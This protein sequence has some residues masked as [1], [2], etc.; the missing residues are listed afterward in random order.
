MSPSC[1]TVRLDH[2]CS[3]SHTH[4]RS[5]PPGWH[6][7][8]LCF[9]GPAVFSL[10]Y[11]HSE[12]FFFSLSQWAL[13]KYLN[14]SGWHPLSVPKNA[15]CLGLI[16]KGCVHI[17]L[18]FSKCLSQ[19]PLYEKLPKPVQSAEAFTTRSHQNA[20]APSCAR[21]GSTADLVALPLVEL[22][23][24]GLGGGFGL[25]RLH[26]QMCH[27][28]L[29]ALF[30]FCKLAGRKCFVILWLQIWARYYYYIKLH[31]KWYISQIKWWHHHTWQ[32]LFH[33]LIIVKSI[34][35]LPNS[36]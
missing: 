33:C 22:S 14:T 2:P 21:V 31:P 35:P 28:G 1:V 16:N 17:I 26:V 11:H 19:C 24:Y 9:H 7:F 12:S 23:T 13:I 8:V 27:H 32:H 18:H 4:C 30:V 10:H 6:A 3:F 29:K 34:R 25:R 15:G 5:A 36:K 20:R